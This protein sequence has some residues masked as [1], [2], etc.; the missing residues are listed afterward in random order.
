[1]NTIKRNDIC[2]ANCNNISVYPEI[3]ITTGDVDGHNYLEVNTM[4]ETNGYLILNRYRFEYTSIN[5]KSVINS[6]NNISGYI[7]KSKADTFNP[8]RFEYA[9]DLPL[10]FKIED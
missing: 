2:K 3:D 8:S 7:E 9:D 6:L 4:V 5:I 10:T 1:M